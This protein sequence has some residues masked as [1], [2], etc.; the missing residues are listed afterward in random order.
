M[1]Y[2]S[3]GTEG[4]MYREHF[5]DRCV[6]QPAADGPDCPIWDAHLAWNGDQ[7][8]NIAVKD[9]LSALIPRS[10][11]GLRNERCRFFKDRQFEAKRR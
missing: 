3:N 2:F 9:I 4:D 11:D 6:H 8:K 5:C 7:H 10:E 1:A